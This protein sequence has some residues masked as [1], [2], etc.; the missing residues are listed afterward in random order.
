MPTIFWREVVWFVV[1]GLDL[2]CGGGLTTFE[3]CKAR[4]QAAAAHRRIMTEILDVV[5]NCGSL[6]NWWGLVGERRMPSARPAA[7]GET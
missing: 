2:H 1:S 3:R 4:A 5:Q 7:G 6:G